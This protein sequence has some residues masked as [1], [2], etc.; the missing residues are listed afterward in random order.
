MAVRPFDEIER[1]HATYGE[2]VG[3]GY[4]PMRF[5]LLC[6]P[7][8]NE[9]LLNQEPDALTWGEAMKTLEVVDGPTA[10]VVTDGE[11]HKRRRRVVQPAFAVRRIDSYRSIMDE[12]LAAAVSSWAPGSEVDAY[13]SFRAAIRRVTLRSL[14]GDEFAT[15]AADLIGVVLDPALHFVDRPIASQIRFG[16]LYQRA[17]RA[18]EQA[19]EV[20]RAEIARRRD[21][22]VERTD[23]LAWLLDSELSEQEVLDQVVSLIAA[24][25]GTTSAAIGWAVLRVLERPDVVERL[26]SGDA[27]YLDAVVQEVLRLHPPG[28]VAPRHVE[29]DVTFKGHRIKKGTLVLYSAL[30]TH[31]MPEHWHDPLSFRPERWL[32]GFEPAP[33]TFVAFGGGPR[34]CIG[35]AMAT[36]EIKAAV[37]ALVARHDVS[38]VPD[39]AITP[40]GIGAM[41]PSPGVRVRIGG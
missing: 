33:Y 4:G 2:V 10:L 36:A 14:F 32:G 5:V 40:K 7:E 23:V 37:S 26:R 41:Y 6:G 35:F 38:L 18:R 39:Q 3:F 19:D 15:T 22:E 17:R 11:E 20:V 25:Y 16:P 8:A 12:E 34:R 28:A 30:V 13:E 1:L 21:S 9:W 24:G 27:E 31:R 29:R